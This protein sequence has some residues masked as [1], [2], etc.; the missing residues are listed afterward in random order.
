MMA[1]SIHVCLKP[2]DC[3]GVYPKAFGEMVFLS[4]LRGIAK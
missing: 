1:D 4:V 3:F 2:L